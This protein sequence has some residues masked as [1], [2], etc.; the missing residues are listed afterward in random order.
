[1]PSP[2]GLRPNTVWSRL[3]LSATLAILSGCASLGAQPG[4]DPVG[5]VA[6]PVVVV[7]DGKHG[8]ESGAH[9]ERAI[10]A[11]E[12]EGR[13]REFKAHLA[14]LTE[15][16]ETLSS[17]NTVEV[18]VDG[19]ATF[20]AMFD[21]IQGA[22]HR[23]FVES[24]IFEDTAI[25]QKM[26]THLL[27]KKAQGLDVRIIYDGV[28]AL[29]TDGAFFE[30]LRDGGIAV[31][32]FN[33]VGVD[34]GRAAPLDVNHRDHRKLLLI[35]DKIAF[36]GG[37]NISS[38]YSRGSV[39][40]EESRG[41]TGE[42][43]GWRDTHARLSGPVAMELLRGYEGTWQ[44][45]N[46]GGPPFELPEPDAG[47]ADAPAGEPADRLVVAILS[48]GDGD[49]ARFYR[50]LLGAIETARTSIHI[51][52]AYFVPNPD[53]L[54]ALKAAARRGVDTEL[55]L[56]GKSDSLLVLRAGQA[57]YEDLLEVGV[58][59]F[60]RHD[61]FLHAKTAVIDGV[62]STVGSSNLD[63]RSF[64]HNDEVNVVILG[65]EVGRE[66][67]A[68]FARDREAAEAV[69]RQTWSDRGLGRRAMELVGRVWQYW[70]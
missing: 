14:R 45:Q 15:L 4:T 70:L 27:A 2:Q 24:Y 49:S 3:A 31:C 64:L 10:K 28:G 23:V 61:R 16:G 60:E 53:M 11:A 56:P 57:S 30:S 65:R 43:E 44:R 48:Q 21:A 59:I 55:V 33:P 51:T 50:A 42:G 5:V 47:E 26:R 34:E 17:D 66:M 69:T 63:W 32:E 39:N 52:M 29:T 1:M 62:W 12:A 9:S 22:E 38:V 58:K 37:V 36:V 67:E 46:C 41:D 19:P 35:D 13:R 8:P 18:L 40:G 6:P 25:G 68:M 7:V 20:A 54:D